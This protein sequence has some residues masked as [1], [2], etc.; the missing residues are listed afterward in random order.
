VLGYDE[1][2]KAIIKDHLAQRGAP[3]LRA[4]AKALKIPLEEVYESVQEIQK[5]ESTP[6]A[7]SPRSTTSRSRSR[8]TST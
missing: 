2:E 1:V 4:I 7:T 6:R 3:Q 8:P 5:L